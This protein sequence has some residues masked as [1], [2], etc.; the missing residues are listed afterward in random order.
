MAVPEE[1]RTRLSHWCAARVPAEERDTRQVAYTIHG[2]AITILERRPPAYPELGAAWSATPVARLVRQGDRWQLE[3][4]AGRGEWQ[5]DS[6]G[7]DPIELLD[8]VRA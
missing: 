1:I 2:D 5:P 6:T 3:R 8:Q 4:P 7:A